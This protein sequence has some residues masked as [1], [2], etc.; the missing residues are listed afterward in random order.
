M[1]LLGWDGRRYELFVASAAELFFKL[2]RIL[3]DPAIE[4]GMIDCHTPLAQH[5]L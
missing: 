3:D 5:L 4:R 1:A 2:G